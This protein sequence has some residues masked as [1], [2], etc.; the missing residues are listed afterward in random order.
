MTKF[1]KKI[2][3]L[4]INKVNPNFLRKRELKNYVKRFLP[5]EFVEHLRKLGE[6][7]TVIDIGANTGI[8]SECLAN[9]GA[10][11]ISF[12]PNKKALA[13]LKKVSARYKNIEVHECAAGIKDREVK[14]Y[15]HKDV[16]RNDDDLTQA[17]SLKSDKPNVSKFKYDKIREIDFALFLDSLNKYVELIKIDIE[18][19]EVELINHL[20]DN[21]SLN[22]IGKIYLE[23]HETKFKAL[24]ESTL[25]LKK[26]IKENRLEKKFIFEWP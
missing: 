10:Y 20:I 4:I 15:L 6:N 5:I 24:E 9:T 2:I 19:Y 8:V 1:L 16:G 26:R 18:G 14:L 23:T 7:D 3:K 22:K 13:Q 25:T 11:T 17:S 12:E 21:N